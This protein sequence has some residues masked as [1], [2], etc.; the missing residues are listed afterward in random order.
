M[1]E[2]KRKMNYQIEVLFLRKPTPIS[3]IHAMVIFTA[4]KCL[5]SP[6]PRRIQNIEDFL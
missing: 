5:T 2:N 3:S 1:S 4:C 6:K